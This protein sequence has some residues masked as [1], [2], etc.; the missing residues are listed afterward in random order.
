MNFAARIDQFLD[1]KVLQKG[2]LILSLAVSIFIPFDG[3]WI[4]FKNAA[5]APSGANLVL[6]GPKKNLESSSFYESVF[7]RD[8]F[9]G[10]VSIHKSESVTKVPVSELAKDLRLKGVIL[11]DEPEAIIEDARIQKTRFVKRNS[12]MGELTVKV[13]KESQVVL[14]AGPGEEITLEIQ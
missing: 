12:R 11:G 14:S 4:S 10:R 9:F 1:L 3:L 8:T 5:A 13:I 2:F 7:E 6:L